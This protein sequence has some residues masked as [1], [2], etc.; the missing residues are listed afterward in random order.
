MTEASPRQSHRLGVAFVILALLRGLR[1][2]SGAAYDP[3]GL[4]FFISLALS[5]P[6]TLDLAHTSRRP[7]GKLYLFPRVQDHFH[8]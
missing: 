5:G 7:G 6:N 3:L 4:L 2:L 8:H 1:K